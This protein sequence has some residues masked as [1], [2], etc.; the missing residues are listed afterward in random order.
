MENLKK[1][2]QEILVQM[3]FPSVEINIEESGGSVLVS[4]NASESELSLLIGRHGEVIN[5]L[6]TISGLIHNHGQTPWQSVSVNLGDYRQRRQEALYSMA[7]RAALNAKT[8]GK[9][10]IISHLPDNERRLI[11]LFLQDD[12]QVETYSEGSGR[13]RH[14]VVRPLV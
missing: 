8:T 14:L 3:S 13:S 12:P 5:A 7:E 6:E 11:H 4:L 9:E 1:T 10:V 2:L